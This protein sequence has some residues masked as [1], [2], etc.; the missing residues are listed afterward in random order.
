M[1]SC[2]MDVE[3]NFIQK[4]ML[5][6]TGKSIAGV[7]LATTLPTLLT[8]CAEKKAELPSKVLNYEYKEASTDAAP[9]P[10]EYQIRCCC[11]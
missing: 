11:N 7:A 4:E 3:E 10:Y 9:H 5:K 6:I 8:G 1:K 2:K